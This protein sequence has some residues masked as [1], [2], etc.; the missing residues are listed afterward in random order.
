MRRIV[1]VLAT[2]AALMAT[3]DSVRAQEAIV[4]G[5]VTSNPASKDWVPK[6]VL[7]QIDPFAQRAAV[8]DDFTLQVFD[9]P[10]FADVT[11]PSKDRIQLDWKLIG[12]RDR[13]DKVQNVRFKMSINLKRGTFTYN[14]V[15]ESYFILPGS[16]NGTCAAKKADS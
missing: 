6:G 8:I 14:G 11:R 12:I 4:L 9:G 5:C 13:T 16:A 7:I 1:T 10:A 15:G 3:P 2:M